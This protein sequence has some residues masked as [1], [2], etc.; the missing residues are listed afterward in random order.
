MGYLVLPDPAVIKSLGLLSWMTEEEVLK[1]YEE[2]KKEIKQDMEESV[3]KEMGSSHVLC[4]KK[5]KE[6]VKICQAIPKQL[7]NW[8]SYS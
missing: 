8:G 4:A 7:I 1:Y 3:K 6:L 2:K 5:V